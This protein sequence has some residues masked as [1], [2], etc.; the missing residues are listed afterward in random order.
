MSLRK[1]PSCFSTM[2]TVLDR[3]IKG[4]SFVYE[5]GVDQVNGLHLVRHLGMH[6]GAGVIL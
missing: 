3:R 5:D 1:A 2:G 4:Q 6:M